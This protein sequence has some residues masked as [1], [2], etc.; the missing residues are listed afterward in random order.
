MISVLSCE[1]LVSGKST[2]TYQHFLG[3]PVVKNAPAKAGDTSSIPGQ[4][5]FHMPRSK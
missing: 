2:D 5:R 3:G 4:G 1:C